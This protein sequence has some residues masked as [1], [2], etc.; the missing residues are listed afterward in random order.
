MRGNPTFGAIIDAVRDTI[1]QALEYRQ[2]QIDRS[3]GGQRRH[4]DEAKSP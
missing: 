3:P 2:I 1:A 4:V